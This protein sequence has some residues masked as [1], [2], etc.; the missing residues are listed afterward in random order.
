[1][2]GGPSKHHAGSCQLEATGVLNT[3]LGDS[4]FIM[5]IVGISSGRFGPPAAAFMWRSGDQVWDSPR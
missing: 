4:E 1:M 2:T 3:L 5:V